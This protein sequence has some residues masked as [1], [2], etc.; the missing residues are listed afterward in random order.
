MTA[1]LS[2]WD[3]YWRNVLVD[4]CRKRDPRAFTGKNKLRYATHLNLGPATP[5]VSLLNGVMLLVDT[6]REKVV[7]AAFPAWTQ[8]TR[9]ARTD[10]ERED[11]DA[12]EGS[13]LPRPTM[14]RSR[15]FPD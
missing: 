13:Q 3:Y 12:L 11:L 4:E 15:S 9:L 10:A 1:G 7:L 6:S 2:E 8:P 14:W 5:G